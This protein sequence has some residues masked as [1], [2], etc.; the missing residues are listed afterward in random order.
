MTRHIIHAVRLF[1]RQ[2]LFTLT[3]VLS[4]A[5]GIGANA[6]IFSAA[7]GILMAPTAGISAP[8]RLVDIGLTRPNS[9]FDTMSYPAFTEMRDRNHTLAG[10]YATRPEPGPL[11]LGAANGAQRIYGQLVS[12]GFFDVLGV[13]PAHGAFFHANQEV[14]GTPLRQVVLSDRFWR[15]AFAADPSIAG[16]DVLING[17]HFTVAAVTPPGFQGTTILAPDV[18]IPMTTYSRT[19]PDDHLLTSRESSWI[20]AGGR[21]KPGV[22][23]AE[24]RQDLGGIIA[25]LAKQFPDAIGTKR[26][27]V[28]T[29]SRVP[30]EFGE[31][32]GPIVAVLAVVV[33]LVLLL[34][35]TN[36]AGMLLARAAAR[37]REM[38]VRVALG[39]SRW[40]IMQQLLAESL[41]LFAA[42]GASAAL[43]ALWMTRTLWSLLPELPFPVNV[44]LAMDWRVLT[45]TFGLALIAGLVTGLIPA[46]QSSRPNLASSMKAD[47]SAPGRQ[48]LRHGLVAAQMGLCLLLLVVAALLLRSLNAAATVDPGFRTN[49]V[50]V[51][52]IDLGLGNYTEAEG[53]AITE[54]VRAG[55]GAIPGVSHVAVAAMV[56]LDGDGLG[57]GG[58]RKKGS[59]SETRELAADW[60]VISP[61]FLPT[62][63]LPIV[64][65]RN[66]SA[67]DRP[68]GERV[69]II[70]ERFAQELWPGE[71]P[72]GKQLESGDFRPGKGKDN[73]TLTIVGVAKNAKYRWIGEAQRNF[74]YVALA[75]E[76][77]RRAKFFVALDHRADAASDLTPAVR[78]ALRTIDPDLPLVDF[79][80][81]TDVAAL[82]MLPQ[83]IAASVAG[84]LGVLALL[85]A[86]IGL[87]GVMAF[88]VTR[89]TRE[90]GVR[91]ALGA[92]RRTVIQM[93]LR[94]GLRLTIGGGLIGLVLAGAAAA[95]LSSAGLLFGVGRIDPIAFGA[96]TVLLVAVAALAT[97]I[98]AR[99][100]AA[101]DPLQA[102]R[103][104]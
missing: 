104:E 15:R 38:S 96:T 29:S 54:R 32:I 34:A 4:L 99:R 63:E 17:D 59:T 51:A 12:A 50:G 5:I 7:N 101:I 72:I 84:S 95:G 8:D 21:L 90:I 76:P 82:G 3:A 93:V 83:L 92:D 47:Q 85:L 49:G 45:F 70:N 81:L 64:R 89:R 80:R 16:R 102:L 23:L 22:T 94:Q 62:L 97:Y 52:N 24:A 28:M 100:A 56:P 98:P 66:F 9:N 86:A 1:A 41:V 25:D 37:S 48:R 39:A 26:I 36:L 67:A 61:E 10:M 27:A 35:C 43:V 11:S 20:I 30:G 60:N 88:A 68:D 18:W 73:H 65:G 31:V 55:L 57:L 6:T 75:Q 53:P 19:T 13:V 44:T 91:M 40:D 58:L 33:G 71:D 77:W 42:G 78:Q 74:I 69:A 87:Y 46:W 2:P 103:A 79:V 14:I